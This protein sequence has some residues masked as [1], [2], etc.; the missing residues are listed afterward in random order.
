MPLPARLMAGTSGLQP[1]LWAR[2]EPP[3]G[4]LASSPFQPAGEMASGDT[5]WYLKKRTQVLL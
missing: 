3:T 1:N 4:L 5:E 2:R